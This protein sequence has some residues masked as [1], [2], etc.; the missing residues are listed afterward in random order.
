MPALTL[1]QVS[2]GLVLSKTSL[3]REIS[4]TAPITFMRD[5]VLC[6]SI[7]SRDV[8]MLSTGTLVRW[9]ASVRVWC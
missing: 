7:Y 5:A 2:A 4:V 3:S 1:P 9:C 8:A 6:H